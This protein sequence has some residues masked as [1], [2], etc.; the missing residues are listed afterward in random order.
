MKSLMEL[1]RIRTE[2]TESYDRLGNSITE[3]DL[4]YD[5]IGDALCYVKALTWEVEQRE[6]V[7]GINPSEE[8]DQGGYL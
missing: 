4:L 5:K 6:R 2:L 7:I 1:H 8:R 3:L